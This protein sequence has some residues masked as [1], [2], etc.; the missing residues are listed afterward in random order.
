MWFLYSSLPAI[1]PNGGPR[2]DYIR[3]GGSFINRMKM[4]VDIQLVILDI[5]THFDSVA[6]LDA[7]NIQVQK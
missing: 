3:R 5:N 7:S 2:H 1:Y 6:F 4:I